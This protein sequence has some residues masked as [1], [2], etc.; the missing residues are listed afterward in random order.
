MFW[1]YNI[2][3]SNKRFFQ[4]RKEI[5][6]WSIYFRG[7]WIRCRTCTGIWRMPRTLNPLQLCHAASLLCGIWISIACPLQRLL[8]SASCRF[9]FLYSVPYA[10]CIIYRFRPGNG[11]KTGWNAMQAS[12]SVPGSP[13]GRYPGAIIPVNI[14]IWTGISGES[15]IWTICRTRT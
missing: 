8:L 14:K 3:N 1:D 9:L 13:C 15:N 7:Q 2:K 12:V 11:Q 10:S 5:S 4:N 6:A